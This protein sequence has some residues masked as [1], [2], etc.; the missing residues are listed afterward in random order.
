MDSEELG[1]IALSIEEKIAE[2]GWDQPHM[3]VAVRQDREI[4]SIAEVAVEAQFSEH[5]DILDFSNLK[6]GEVTALGLVTE[7]WTYPMDDMLSSEDELVDRLN[8]PNTRRPREH[9][10][11]VELRT[12]TMMAPDGQHAVVM[13]H[14]GGEPRTMDAVLGGRVLV[15]LGNLLGIGGFD[16]G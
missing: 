3:L 5:P 4:P 15:T 6:L 16:R 10:G 13:R 1:Q 14:R 8:D 12:V 7:C 9:P 2:D 11:R